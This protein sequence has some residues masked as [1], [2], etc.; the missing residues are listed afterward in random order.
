MPQHL[1]AFLLFAIGCLIF[2]FSLSFDWLNNGSPGIGFH[3]LAGMTMGLTII[4]IGMRYKLLPDQLKW[5]WL[6]FALYLSGILFVGLWPSESSDFYQN[7]LLGMDIFSKRDLALNV[8][9]FVPLGFLI[10]PLA[11]HIM[12]SNKIRKLVVAIAMG[13]SISLVIEVLQFIWIP[14]RYSSSYDLVT[15]TLGTTFGALCWLS[16]RNCRFISLKI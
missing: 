10:L 11:E 16:L 8:V 13:F 4:L 12:D 2:L 7:T 9:G 14:G 3:Q 15:N 5:D 1:L 6:L